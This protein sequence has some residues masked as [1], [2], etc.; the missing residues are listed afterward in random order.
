MS[1][2]NCRFLDLA[3]AKTPNN[4]T[5]RDKHLN[6]LPWE[7]NDVQDMVLH[8]VISYVPAPKM[9]TCQAS[10]VHRRSRLTT[11]CRSNSPRSAQGRPPVM[12][13]LNDFDVCSSFEKLTLLTEKIPKSNPLRSTL[14]LGVDCLTR[15]RI[16]LP[17]NQCLT[18]RLHIFRQVRH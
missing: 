18:D 1:K 13:I 11:V 10:Q 5:K 3:K 9:S 4:P 17:I 15:K 12:A 14:L 7:W 6:L 8:N 2:L 16:H